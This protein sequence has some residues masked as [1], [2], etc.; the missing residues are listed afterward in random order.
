MKKG[1]LHALFVLSV[2]LVIHVGCDQSSRV[3][4]PDEATT[5]NGYDV[6]RI[7]EVLSLS[8]ATVDDSLFLASLPEDIWDEVELYII[9]HDVRFFPDSQDN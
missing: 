3:A 6:G 4:A 8:Q 7:V 9:E 2:C 1:L 5:E